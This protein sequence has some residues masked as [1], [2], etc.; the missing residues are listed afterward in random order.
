MFK[1]SSLS[2]QTKLTWWYDNITFSECHFLFIYFKVFLTDMFVHVYAVIYEESKIL[3]DH[4]TTSP[5]EQQP[6]VYGVMR[7]HCWPAVKV[8]RQEEKQRRYHW[9]A[10]L[11][12]RRQLAG[13]VYVCS[14]SEVLALSEFIQREK[15]EVRLLQASRKEPRRYRR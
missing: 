3:Q 13:I 7:T 1:I 8:I 11:W 2:A 10:R 5:P 6:V 12:T 9:G 14:C 15:R 4:V